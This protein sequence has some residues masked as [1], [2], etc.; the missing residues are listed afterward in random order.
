MNALLEF[1]TQHRFK[2]NQSIP[3][4][5]NTRSWVSSLRAVLLIIPSAC[6]RIVFFF[7]RCLAL[8]SLAE[9]IDKTRLNKPIKI[10]LPIII[11]N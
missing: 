2:E 7:K 5:F 9:Y 8:M 4:E 10:T 11:I 3:F 1:M 6:A